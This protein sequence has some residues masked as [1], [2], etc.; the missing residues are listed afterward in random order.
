MSAEKIA[1]PQKPYTVD[2]FFDLIQDGEKADLI[3]GVI[4]M[5]SPDTPNNDDLGGFLF[6][7]MR[8][9]ARGKHLGRVTGSRVAYVLGNRRAPEPDV[10]FVR[11][12]RL[13][14]IH[15]TRVVGPPDIAIE[16]VSQDSR[17]RDYDLKRRLYEDAGVGE[18]WIID[19]IARRHEFLR[20]REGAFEPVSLNQD[21]YF[22]SD[23]LTGFWLDVTWLHADPLPAE[24]DCLQQILAGPPV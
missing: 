20:L 19:P 9:Y 17:E 23:V 14:R 16:V 6:S 24:M 18:Y 15:R 21:R 7:I 11:Q 12:G 2:E 1:L 4:H 8:F 5:A 22:L 3:D 13:D 10:A